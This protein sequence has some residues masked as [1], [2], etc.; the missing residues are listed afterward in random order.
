VVW[1]ALEPVFADVVIQ[2]AGAHPRNEFGRRPVSNEV[3]SH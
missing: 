1:A 3:A 2:Q